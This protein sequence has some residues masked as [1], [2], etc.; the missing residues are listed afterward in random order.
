MPQ[1]CVSVGRTRHAVM[2]QIHERFAQA[3]AE[4]IELRV[5]WLKRA[6][7]FK[8][9]L[10]DRPSPVI[11]TCRRLKEFGKFKGTEDERLAILRNAVASGADYVDLEDDVAGKIPRYGDTKRIVSHHDLEKTPKDLES[12]HK[13]LADL[14]P[15]VIKIATMAN[16]PVD[17]VRVLK[18]V[19]ESEIPTVGFCMGEAGVFSRILCG[20]YGSPITYATFSEDRQL[21]PGQMDFIKMRKTFR[22]EKISEKTAVFGVVGDPVAHSHSPVIH[23]AAFRADNLNAVYVPFLVPSDAFEE[24]MKALEWLGVDG[25][26]V[27]IPHKEAA[28]RWTKYKTPAVE[29][30]GAA[31][32]LYRNERGRWAAENTDM[33]AALSTIRDA[34]P[35]GETLSGKAVLMLGAGGVSKAIGLGLSKAGAALTV[36][37]RTKARGKELAKALGCK[38]VPWENRATVHADVVVNGTRL[39]MSPDVDETPLPEHWIKE[40]CLVFDTVYNP[41]NTLLLKDA[42]RRN[43]TTASGLEMFV[44]QAADQYE[45]FTKRPAP[46]DVMREAL[47][48]EI[49][50]WRVKDDEEPGGEDGPAGSPVPA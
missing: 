9:L 13:R 12:L 46:V 44:R 31:N 17:A 39:G 7:D 23:N 3:G 29:E 21:A 36:T 1:I 50:V 40:G 26:S 20:R 2:R 37:N 22:F 19:K 27:T 14:D 4:L 48:R 35:E 45:C 6:P 5:D 32:T 28:A 24:T 8:Y 33:S 42:R 47:R 43:C 15:D 41:E 10:T 16:S 11:V 30:S 25:F 49:A 34:L 18:L 38:F